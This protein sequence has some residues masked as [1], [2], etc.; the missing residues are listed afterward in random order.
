MISV[1]GGMG[2]MAPMVSRVSFTGRR[3]SGEK[4][5]A[6][7][8]TQPEGSLAQFGADPMHD[9]SLHGSSNRISVNC[10]PQARW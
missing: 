3:R 1:F 6:A 10:P 7:G 2:A 9:E 4:G 8:Y 5:A